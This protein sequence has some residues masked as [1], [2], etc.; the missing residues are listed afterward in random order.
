[1]AAGQNGESYAQIDVIIAGDMHQFRITVFPL[2]GV[3]RNPDD[4]L[5]CFYDWRNTITGETGRYGPLLAPA[6]PNVNASRRG[7]VLAD[8]AQMRGRG[9]PKSRSPVFNP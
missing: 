3:Y 8:L 6:R 9:D 5:N 7:R 4:T 1:M 2:N